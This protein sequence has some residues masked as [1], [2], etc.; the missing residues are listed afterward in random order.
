MT[1]ETKACKPIKELNIDEL[2][3]LKTTYT[4][5]DNFLKHPKIWNLQLSILDVDDDPIE[6]IVL[7]YNLIGGIMAALQDLCDTAE[8]R[9]NILGYTMQE[10]PKTVEMHVNHLKGDR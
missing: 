6:T 4:E 8:H 1:I 3:N 7:D 9:L 2:Y 5:I 10:E